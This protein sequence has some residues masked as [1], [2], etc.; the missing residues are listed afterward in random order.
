M[1]AQ[2]AA[3]YDALDGQVFFSHH[4]EQL[5]EYEEI[6]WLDI[7]VYINSKT[8]KQEAL[9]T[10][11][12]RLKYVTDQARQTLKNLLDQ[13]TM[14]KNA[15]TTVQS[16]IKNTQQQIE[17]AYSERNSNALMD[18]VAHLDELMLVQQ[19]HKY[20]QVFA[21]QTA[22]QYQKIIQ[23]SEKKMQ[24]IEANIP[25]LSQWIQVKM[26][27]GSTLSD[28]EKLQIFSRDTQ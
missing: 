6:A 15:L 17:T 22:T 16:E 24:I 5:T 20:G 14:H 26:P 3:I 8:N 19:D 13:A 2:E 23:F 7:L 1:I 25:A 10:Y 4:F 9:Y 11:L 28:L 21:Q 12:D 27:Q 18:A